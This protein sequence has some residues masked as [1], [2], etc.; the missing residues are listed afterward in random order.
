M[1]SRPTVLILLG[2]L[3]IAGSAQAKD[4]P[5]EFKVNAGVRP[6][7]EVD[8]RKGK[9]ADYF[10]TNQSR[11][12]VQATQGSWSVFVQPQDVRYFGA[13]QDTVS[14]ENGTDLHQGYLEH[15]NGKKY[16]IRVGRQEIKYLNERLIGALG[17]SQI[18]RSFDAVRANGEFKRVSWD[19]FAASTST[20]SGKGN[21]EAGAAA[22]LVKWSN[23]GRTVAGLVVSKFNPQTK[24]YSWTGGPYTEGKLWGPLGYE[25]EAYYQQGH[26]PKH[27]PNKA[28]LASA[29][30]KA[31][32]GMFRAGLGHDIVSGDT[33]DKD[34]VAFDTLYATNHKFYGY[35][36]LFT[37]LPKHTLGAGLRDSYA[38]VGAKKGRWDISV[39]GHRFRTAGTLAGNYKVWGTEWDTIA[40]WTASKSVSVQGGYTFL[41]PGAAFEKNFKKAP[42]TPNWSYLMV[43][44]AL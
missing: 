2:S 26:N 7:A 25:A 41:E 30:L 8:H 23:M 21:K 40:T 15:K 22:G 13:E 6:R 1:V 42:P 16:A 18:G 10:A 4:A 37:N 43:T 3:A 19:A 36:D 9:T 14:I 28:Y 33:K 5:T 20:A 12:S 17:W 24:T 29:Q 27:A 31:S 34:T 38:S 35:M 11:L 32:Y 44:A 39:T